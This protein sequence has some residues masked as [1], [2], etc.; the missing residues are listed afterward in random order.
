MFSSRN[1]GCSAAMLAPN[2]FQRSERNW[3]DPRR[4]ESRKHE[5]RFVRDDLF[6]DASFA[7]SCCND[8]PW[9]F[10]A[11]ALHFGLSGVCMLTRS[12]RIEVS[13][14]PQ[15]YQVATLFPLR[16]HLDDALKHRGRDAACQFV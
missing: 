9:L 7:S 3:L 14:Q 5:I 6:W 13:K 12:Q 15:R 1:V 8:M 11:R 10:P 2:V 16:T 4:G